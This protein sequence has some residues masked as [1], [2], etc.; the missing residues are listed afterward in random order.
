MFC[1]LRNRSCYS[2]SKAVAIQMRQEY[3]KAMLY[4]TG[5]LTLPKHIALCY[6]YVFNSVM[7][8][9]IKNRK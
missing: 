3:E 2:R 1:S 7:V 8:A 4:F 5:N 9:A 6:Y